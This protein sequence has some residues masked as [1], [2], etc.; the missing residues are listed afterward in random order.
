MNPHQLQPFMFTVGI[1][2]T[3]VRIVKEFLNT[4]PRVP[5]FNLLLDDNFDLRTQSALA[6]YQNIKRLPVTD[7][8]MD[9]ETWAAVGTDL[10]PAKAQI[11]LVQQPLL[12]N[13]FNSRSEE[14]RGLSAD[15]IKLAQSIYKSSINYDKVKVHKAKY[16]DAYGYGQTDNTLMTPNGEIYAS[17]NVYSTSY[18]SESDEFKCVFLHEMCHVWQWQRNIKNIK[19]SAAKEFFL[20]PFDYDAAYFYDLDIKKDF[21]DYGIE[22]QASIIED[23]CRVVRYELNW[24]V[25]PNG[26]LRC[27]SPAAS[28]FNTLLWVLDTFLRNPSYLGSDYKN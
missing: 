27:Q 12:R 11:V 7:G 4:H 1:R 24:N 6:A 18:S 13:L 19:A 25:A 21:A 2:H 14:G 5:V 8:T 15:E 9:A 28:R 10:N 16:I 20:H 22:Q 26:K 3:A 17:P 23:Y